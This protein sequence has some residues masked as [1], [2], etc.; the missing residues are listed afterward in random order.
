M[1][2]RWWLDGQ[3]VAVPIKFSKDADQKVDSGEAEMGEVADGKLRQCTFENIGERGAQPLGIGEMIPTVEE[4]PFG[5]PDGVGGEGS[6]K[7]GHPLQ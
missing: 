7:G 6:N 4:D 2:C 1:A 5:R 3:G